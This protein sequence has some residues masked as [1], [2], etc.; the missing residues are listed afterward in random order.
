MFIKKLSI[1]LILISVGHSALAKS[2]C[3]QSYD[4]Q[5]LDSNKDQFISQEEAMDEK[6]LIKYWGIINPD[7]DSHLEAEEL[8]KAPK[9][10]AKE[11]ARITDHPQKVEQYKAGQYIR[12]E[13]Q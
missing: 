8:K 3:P 5:A 4:Y 11:E 7:N 12:P 10:I 13:Q 2:S 1:T 9:I 6:C